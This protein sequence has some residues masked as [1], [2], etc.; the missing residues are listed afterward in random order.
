M[1]SDSGHTA[2][3]PEPFH[4]RSIPLVALT[5]PTLNASSSTSISSPDPTIPPE[6]PASPIPPVADVTSPISS[7]QRFSPQT[8]HSSGTSAAPED[9]PLTPSVPE[10]QPSSAS[11]TTIPHFVPEDSQ[12]PAPPQRRE[13]RRLILALWDG[14]RTWVQTSIGIAALVVALVGLLFALRGYNIAKWT[15][16]NDLLQ[17]CAALVQVGREPA[18]ALITGRS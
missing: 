5:R 1:E 7:H 4:D 11:S 6:T 2:V 18:L 13:A 14:R 17:S 10:L 3:A 8:T 9:N 12:A 15:A 16:Y